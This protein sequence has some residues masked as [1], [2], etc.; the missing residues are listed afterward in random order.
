MHPKTTHERVRFE[1]FEL[2]LGSGELF[3]EGRKVQLQEPAV[4]STPDSA[5]TFRTAGDQGGAAPAT[6]ACG[7]V[8]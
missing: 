5:G 3:Y 6:L 7:Y 8:C 2:D 4:P 1:G